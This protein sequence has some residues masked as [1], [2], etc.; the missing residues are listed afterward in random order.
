VALRELKKREVKRLLAQKAE[1]AGE[2]KPES[3][4]ARKRPPRKK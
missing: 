2:N 4:P 1:E 3:K